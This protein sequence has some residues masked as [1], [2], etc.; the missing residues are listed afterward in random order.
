MRPPDRADRGRPGRTARRRLRS[1]RSPIALVSSCIAVFALCAAWRSGGRSRCCSPASASSAS[2]G[3]RRDD[4]ERGVAAASTACP[5][6][7]PRAGAGQAARL[8]DDRAGGTGPAPDVGRLSRLAEP[9]R[10]Y[11]LRHVVSARRARPDPDEDRRQPRPASRHPS[12]RSPRRGA[13]PADAAGPLRTGMPGTSRRRTPLRHGFAPATTEPTAAGPDAPDP[14]RPARCVRHAH[15]P[16]HPQHRLGR[17]RHA[18]PSSCAAAHAAGLDVVAITDHDTTAGWDEAARRPPGR[19]HGRAAASSSPASTPPTDGRRI[20]LHL[21]AYL[22]DPDDAAHR[23]PSGNA[24]ATAGATAAGRWSSRAGRRRLPDQLGPG[25]RPRR[26]RLGRAAAHRPRAGRGRRGARRD[27]PPSRD[28]LSSRQQYYVRKADTDV[29]DAIRWS[30]AAGGLPVFAHPLARRRG[31]IVVDDGVIAAMAA[32]GHGRPRGRPPRPRRRRPSRTPPVWP[33][34]SGC[35]ARARRTTTAPTRP[36][37]IG[38]VPDR[39]RRLRAAARAAGRARAD[40]GLNVR[41]AVTAIPSGPGDAWRHDD[42]GQPGGQLVLDHMPTRLFACTPS[43][44]AAFDC[45]RRYRFTYLDRPAPP[46]GPPWGAQHRRRRRPPGPAPLVV[47]AARA[48][49]RPDEGAALVERHWQSRR[50]PRRA[51][52]ATGL[53]GHGR[54]G[55]RLPAGTSTRP[56]SRSASSAPSPPAPSASRCRG[57]VDRID[58]REG[59]LVVVDYKTGRRGSDRRR[60]PRVAG[61]R[62]VRPRRAPHP[63]PCVP[64]RRAAPPAHRHGR[65]R[66]TTPTSRWA[67]TCSAPRPPPQDIVTATDTLAAGA[68]PDEVFPAGAGAGLFV[69]RLPAHCPEGR[70]ASPELDAVGRAR[71]RRLRP[72]TDGRRPHRLA[73][74]NPRVL[75]WGGRR[76]ATE[77]GQR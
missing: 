45:P 56:T 40:L 46:R 23:R 44:L 17:H 52:R 55:A 29:F 49:A 7:A 16:A 58:E 15:R 68:D 66:S 54:V 3:I 12:R 69:V 18:R 1:G 59:E 41:P 42:D 34:S 60:R 33:A 65:R 50:L 36:T 4:L 21:L 75:C 28:L 74:G 35:S 48:T 20:S 63:A 43:R 64:T 19:A 47:A 70:A 6:C 26:R 51:C 38:A 13:A 30:A 57:R 25:Q 32:A 24:C 37:P 14:A 61:A 10:F 67:A 77:A 22:S 71:R 39:P 76:R 9:E 73:A 72:L 27:R 8:R 62:A 2:S 5:V 53:R 11:W 31:P